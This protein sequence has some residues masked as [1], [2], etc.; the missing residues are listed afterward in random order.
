MTVDS[1]P[2]YH[3]ITARL[4]YGEV[5][6]D[7]PQQFAEAMNAGFFRIKAPTDLNLEIGRAFARTFTSNPRYNNFGKL[8]EFNGFL[9]SPIAQ[10]VRFC[11]ERDFWNNEVDGTP[12]FPPELQELA[13]KMQSIG[14]KVLQSILKKFN[15]PEELWFKATAGAAHNEGSHYLLFN[16]YDPKDGQIKDGLGAHKDWGHITVLD[17]TEPGLQAKVEGQWR[18][19]FTE[20]GFLIIN[21]GEP[22]EKLLPQVKA[23]EHRVVTQTD[24]MR[25]S[26][27]SFTDP[28]V[29]PF[30]QGVKSEDK[31]GYVYDW[32]PVN[33]AL[34]NGQT[35][36]DFYEKM[37]KELFDKNY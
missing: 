25:T 20:D 6:F 26:T 28:R 14:I 17:A 36:S 23:S 9:K 3:M 37:S 4:E 8:D 24:K 13:N 35:A 33:K 7:T 30:R 2:T 22:L 19:L 27:V 34:V 11:L 18:N 10:S 1:I 5:T 29:G 31:E 21:F 16:C 32:D 12:I 15:L